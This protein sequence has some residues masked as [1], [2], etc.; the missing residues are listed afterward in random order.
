[1]LR[2]RLVSGCL[3]GAAF[4][5]ACDYLP[6]AGMWILLTVV[7]ALAQFEFYQMI[8]HAHI[9]VFRCF[10]LCFGAALITATCWTVGPTPADMARAYRW[11]NVV[12]LATLIGIFV[13]LFPQKHNERPVATVGCTLLGIWYVPF[14]M[15]Y[16]ARLAFQWSD[17]TLT[18]GVSETG[19]LLILYMVVVV[20]TT[21]MGAYFVGRLVGR[22][23]L[24]KRVSPS[25]TWEGLVGG[26][27]AA[28]LSSWGFYCLVDGRLGVI[29]L[30]PG[31]A[32]A[33][34]VL[35]SISGVAG[36][37]FESL[38]K[39]ACGIKDSGQIL[40]GMGG[41]LDVLDSLLFGAPILY[42]YLRL[43]LA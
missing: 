33:L 12:L 34:G 13:R 26:I 24:W 23:K 28:V 32:I 39:R 8:S 6:M 7:T 4:V 35:L 20:K 1:M 5:L 14:L 40:P 30:R 22:H 17:A 43:V 25:K 3:L 10:G 9:P 41:L 18:A 31:D 29:L 19:R 36:D 21:D 37:L 15:N 38:V 42:V 11:E 2:H 27:A 16:F